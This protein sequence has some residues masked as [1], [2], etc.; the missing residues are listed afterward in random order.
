M[1]LTQAFVGGVLD[2]IGSDAGDR[3]PAIPRFVVLY[4]LT[5][6][7]AC[8]RMLKTLRMGGT[9][10]FSG[11]AGFF[12]DIA[13]HGA[14]YAMLL[15]GDAERLIAHVPPS[16][17]KPEVFGLAT[18]GAIL[19]PRLREALLAKLASHVANIY[20]CNEAGRICVI[21]DNGVG[22]V[23]PGV[24]VAIVDEHG[25]EKPYGETGLIKVKSGTMIEGYLDNPALTAASFRDGWF[26]SSDFGMMPGPG[27][28]VVLGRS[29]DMLNVGGRKL[30]PGPI[31]D[32]LKTV[33][34][35]RDAAAFSAANSNGVAVLVVAIEADLAGGD[36]LKAALV[37]AVR[38][39]VG[40]CHIMVA[41][42][43]PR[44]KNGKIRRRA[45]QELFQRKLG[46]Q[47]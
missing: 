15:V 4:D 18:V 14:N 23:T 12:Q 22:T 16:F 7:F 38:R 34:G 24:T 47:P 45:L 6:E 2:Q 41:K 39:N 30:A 46:P 43:L 3:I 25:R 17:A 42:S 21:D 10:I 31:E 44:T 28:L 20:G 29:D 19:S 8:W 26:H 9:V 36:N 1:A 27:R 40:R 35:V 37:D 13:R 11:H 5:V 32:R 33:P